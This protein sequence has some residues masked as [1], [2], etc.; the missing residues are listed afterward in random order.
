MRPR[1]T[2]RTGPFTGLCIAIVFASALATQ[3]AQAAA[4]AAIGPDAPLHG[5]RIRAET[6]SSVNWAGYAAVGADASFTSVSASWVQPAPTCTAGRS[7][8]SYWVGL[9]G[10][11]NGTVEQLGTDSDCFKGQAIHYAW[12]EFFPRYPRL[13]KHRVMPGDHLSASVLSTGGQAFQ[14]SMTDSTLGW[15]FSVTD[16]LPGATRASAEFILEASCCNKAGNM[17]RLANFGSV[18]ITGAQVNGAPIG[19]TDPIRL[20]IRPETFPTFSGKDNATTSDLTNGTDFSIVWGKGT[21]SP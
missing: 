7:F 16:T 12:Y 1:I 4:A 6:Q 3:G 19:D 17:L 14:L 21:G 11:S 5:P 20:N 10:F 18:D 13:I 9:D 8:A 15:T 2:R